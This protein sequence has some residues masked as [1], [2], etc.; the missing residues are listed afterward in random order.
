MAVPRKDD[1][2]PE[3]L[4][5]EPELTLYYSLD[6]EFK[7]PSSVYNFMIVLNDPSPTLEANAMFYLFG[8]YLA[9]VFN[10][11]HGYY[12]SLAEAGYSVSHSKE[13]C[14]KFRVEGY[15]DNLEKFV[16]S[17]FSTLTA[18]L[19]ASSLDDFDCSLL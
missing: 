18:M 4:L 9:E 8:E 15:E 16:G 13:N 1:Y 6:E 12:G 7:M 2:S 14:L 3:K 11:E 5:D 19:H 10:I 17:F